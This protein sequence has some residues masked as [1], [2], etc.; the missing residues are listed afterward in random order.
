MKTANKKVTAERLVKDALAKA[1]HFEE[2][3]IFTF[4]DEKGALKRAKEIDKRIAAG[5]KVG[6]LAGVPFAIKD[7][8]MHPCGETTASAHILEGLSSPITM[9]PDCDIP[10]QKQFYPQ[11]P[12]N[13]FAAVCRTL[14]ENRS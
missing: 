8:F 11:Y 5:E 3:H 12:P 1:K 6:R 4:I 10:F 13:R 14:W 9:P 2:Y 7:N